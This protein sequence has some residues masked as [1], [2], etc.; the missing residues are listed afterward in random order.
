[1]TVGGN[2]PKDRAQAAFDHAVQHELQAIQLHER[3]AVRHDEIAASYEQAA[4]Q[5]VGRTSKEFADLA[6]RERRRAAE[7]RFRADAAR[8]RL[9]AEGIDPGD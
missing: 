8:T 5:G 7:A 2:A 6:R 3:A 1:M 4:E 9:R